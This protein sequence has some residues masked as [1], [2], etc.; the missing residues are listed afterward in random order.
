MAHIQNSNPLLG[1]EYLSEQET[2]M[3][4]GVSTRTLYRRYLE[5][6][7]LPRIVTGR[8]TFNKRSSV[9]SWLDSREQ[10]QPRGWQVS[11][12]RPGIRLRWKPTL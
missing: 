11:L 4:L 8:K 2:A 12:M 3:S 1:D 7:V 5:R 9:L 6:T 10:H